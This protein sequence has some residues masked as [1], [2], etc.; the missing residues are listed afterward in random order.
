M[1][2]RKNYI[3][4]P[5]V[6]LSLSFL[7]QPILVLDSLLSLWELSKKYEG[8]YFTPWT[9]VFTVRVKFYLAFSLL[10]LICL[11]IYFFIRR[12]Y[13]NVRLCKIHLWLVFIGLVVIPVYDIVLSLFVKKEFHAHS[14]QIGNMLFYDYPFLISFFVLLIGSVFFILTVIKSS[15]LPKINPSDE[16][17]GFLDDFAQ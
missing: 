10:A 4:L 17:T 6:L 12:R 5:I 7:F 16:S 3:R 1:R 15:T 8:E 11:L 14:F 2:Y 13:I 9:L